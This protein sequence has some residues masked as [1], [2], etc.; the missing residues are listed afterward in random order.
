MQGRLSGSRALGWN[1]D[2]LKERDDRV[3]LGVD[4]VG[5][6]EDEGL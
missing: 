5:E 4:E 1:G 6:G 3:E 2:A